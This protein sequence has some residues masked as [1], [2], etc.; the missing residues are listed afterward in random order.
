MTNLADLQIGVGANLA[1]LKSD[2]GKAPAIAEGAV[3]GIA[4]KF[5]RLKPAL[6]GAAKAAGVAAGAALAAG[7][8]LGIQ[9]GNLRAKLG[10]QLNLSPA[11]TAKAAKTAGG[12]MA[13]GIT[14]S[15]GEVNDAIGA[16]VGGGLADLGDSKA[17]DRLAA[18]ALNLAD[19]WDMDVNRAV[20][21]AGSLLESGLAKDADH[22]FDLIVASSQ[23]VK[24]AL[25]DELGDATAEYSRF[26]GDLGFTG[27]QAL[28]MLAAADDRFELDKTGD[29]IKELSI[30]AT[31]MSTTSVAA[32]DAMGMDAKTMAD[33]ILAGGSTARGAFDDIVS[34]LLAI[35]DPTKRANAAIGLFGTPIEDLGTAKIPQFLRALRDAGGEL[36]DVSGRAAK[37]GETMTTPSRKITGFANRVKGMLGQVVQAPG[38]IGD[39]ATAVAGFGTVL[40]PV[41][42]ALAGVGFVFQSQ[43]SSMASGFGRLIAAGATWVAATVAQGAR[44]V[45]SMVATA[46][47]MAGRWAFMAARSLA[48]AARMAASWVI[49]MGPVG[50]VIAAVVGVT[51]LIV[52]NWDKVKKWTIRAWRA[53]SDAVKR[54]WKAVTGWVG[55]MADSVRR[56][57]GDVVGWCGWMRDRVVSLFRTL[58][59][60]IVSIV[61]SAVNRVVGF[62]QTLRDRAVSIARGVR[63]GVVDR[64]RS[65]VDFVRS[66]PRRI[67][68]VFSGAGRWLL[69]AG[70]N[71]IGGL[72]GGI[73]DKFAGAL[74][75]ARS[76]AAKIRNLWP[77]SPAKEGPLARYPMDRAGANIVSMLADGMASQVPALSRMAD[78]TARAA[79]P[80][81][82]IAAAPMLPAAGVR[83]GDVTAGTA[84]GATVVN[85]HVQGS[86]VTERELVDVVRRGLDKTSRRNAGTGIRAGA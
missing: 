7:A 72:I 63:D 60:G 56:L 15:L 8:L 82:G 14:D 12:L 68:A 45:G 38:I 70:R 1:G 19:V 76:L 43:L 41:G 47:K 48:A 52:A 28:G 53:V 18:K 54:A 59:D 80:R 23:K 55:R 37:L 67:L 50:W 27:A 51:A 73:R 6:A 32:F 31:D 75:L 17:V 4:A 24:P 9:Q 46:A 85:V 33:R 34:G 61:R 2:L 83:G 22:A 3:D 66:I 44:A 5:D 30:R 26:F 20:S 11:D 25:L 78:R 42:P 35:E 10:A 16:V 65:T 21:N 81:L 39:A 58:R 36:T 79:M 29:A 86:V 77:F 49:A 84:G 13:K 57:V 64:F 62:F 71:L 69:D 40:Q 74:D